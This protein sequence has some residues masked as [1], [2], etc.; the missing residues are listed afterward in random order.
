M[1]ELHEIKQMLLEQRNLFNSL[2]PSKIAISFIC[3]KTGMTRQG[4]RANLI[5]NY[6]PETD[7]WKEGGK[8]YMSKK[9]ALQLLSIIGGNNDE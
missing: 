3:E 6:E 2:F 7:F 9:V 4:V 5:N 8:I 1:K